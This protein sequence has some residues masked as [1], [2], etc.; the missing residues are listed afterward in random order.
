MSNTKTDFLNSFARWTVADDQPLSVGESKEFRAMIRVANLK[1][2]PPDNKELKRKL[3][4]APEDAIHDEIR[5]QIECFKDNAKMPFLTTTDEYNCPLKWW[6]EN[7]TKYPDV[8]DLAQQILHIPA[9]SAP[10]E[11]VFSSASNIINKKRVRL[12]PE[13]ANLLIFL[14]DY[15]DFAEW[16]K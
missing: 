9:T 1:L 15:Q 16:D 8:W 10:A 13:N 3:P 2:V 14:K 12:S 4:I 6:S 7:W 5:K 11:R